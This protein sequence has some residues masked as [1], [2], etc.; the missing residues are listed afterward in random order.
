MTDR[1][2]FSMLQVAVGQKFCLA[3][4]SKWLAFGPY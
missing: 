2:T 4:I 1:A 3:Q